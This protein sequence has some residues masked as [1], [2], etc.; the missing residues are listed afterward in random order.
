MS[1]FNIISQT[2]ALESSE[3]IGKKTDTDKTRAKLRP[4]GGIR[5]IASD[6]EILKPLIATNGFMFP[7]RPTISWSSNISYGTQN[8]THSIQDFKYF[9]RNNSTTFNI[10]GVFT[11]E[12]TDT[13]KYTLACLH[14]LRSVSKMHFGGFS[15]ASTSST[16]TV[17]SSLSN[18][19]TTPVSSDPYVGA[20][21]PVLMFDCYGDYMFN[22]LPVILES[23]SMD[24]PNDVDYVYVTVDDS[25]ICL[26]V[27]TNIT[28]TVTTQ[29]TP[30]KCRQFNYSEFAN[31]S[32]MK[33]GGWF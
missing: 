10:S 31:G 29:N 32:L 27:I 6:S 14:F 25:K 12:N 13:A 23:F 5:S 8:L 20:P 1:I 9:V 17:D 18:L 11:S 24:F 2:S 26:P 7:Y 15:D 4:K 30:Q 21:P 3:V 16:S 19:L 28:M 33:K 22:K